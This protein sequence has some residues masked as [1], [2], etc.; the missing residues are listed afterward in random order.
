MFRG[1]W[2]A[3][4]DSRWEQSGHTLFPKLTQPTADGAV[5]KSK[6]IGLFLDRSLSCET[7][8]YGVIS[9]LNFTGDGNGIKRQSK[10]N[11]H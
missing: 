2:F 9:L 1:L 7:R 6:N 5:R 11:R 8:G 10:L 3:W 4:I